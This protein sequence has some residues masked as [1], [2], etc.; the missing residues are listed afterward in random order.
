MMV[1][2]DDKMNKYTKKKD[3]NGSKNFLKKHGKFVGAGLLALV[4]L[5]LVV[6][7]QKTP[8]D[9]TKVKRLKRLHQMTKHLKK[10]I[11]GAAHSIKEAAKKRFI[12]HKNGTNVLHKTKKLQHIA[13]AATTGDGH[14]KKETKEH[15]VHHNE[16]KEAGK[17]QRLRK[18]RVSKSES[19]KTHAETTDGAKSKTTTG[20]KE[21]SKKTEKAADK[22][23][24][25]KP[26]EIGNAA[27]MK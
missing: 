21:K 11:E 16:E 3:K 5:L 17:K 9:H 22:E 13:K 6:S 12:H 23:Q 15:Q 24:P 4:V 25:V 20:A 14:D 27:E 2:H 18:S 8:Q 19:K 26:D 10:N 7:M 1:Y